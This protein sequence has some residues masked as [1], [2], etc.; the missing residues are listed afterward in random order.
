MAATV[1][2]IPPHLPFDERVLLTLLWRVHCDQTTTAKRIR[3]RR[4]FDA[5][6]KRAEESHGA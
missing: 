4:A 3:T 2:R 6:L 5:A 1:P